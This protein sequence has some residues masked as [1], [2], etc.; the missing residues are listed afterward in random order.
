MELANM[1]VLHCQPGENLPIWIGLW[2]PEGNDNYRWRS[3]G[4]PYEFEDFGEAVR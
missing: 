4:E 3:N 2:D 1:S